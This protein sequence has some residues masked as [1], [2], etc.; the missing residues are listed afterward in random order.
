MYFQT[1]L[2]LCV[3][4]LTL[5]YRITAVRVIGRSVTIP[6]RHNANLFCQLTDTQETLTRI[7]WQKRTREKPENS[8]FFAITPDGEIEHI[9]GL[10]DRAEFIGNIQELIGSIGLK[11]VSL[12]D[13]GV[14]TCIFNIFPSGPFETEI[15]LT[16]LVP[17]VV[18][19]DPAIIPVAGDGNV[20]LASCTAAKGRPAAEVSWHLGTLADFLKVNTNQS[21]HPDGTYT[22]TSHLIGVA[23]KELNQVKIQCLVNHTALKTTLVEDYTIVIHYPPQVAYIS[24]VGNAT[25]AQEFLCEADGNPKPSSFTWRRVN[26][27]LPIPADN[28]RLLIPLTSDHNGLYLCEA[29]NQYG[30]VTGSIYVHVSTESSTQTPV[31]ILLIIAVL[32]CFVLVI[33]FR[34][35]LV[36]CLSQLWQR[37]SNYIQ[38]HLIRQHAQDPVPTQSPSQNTLSGRREEQELS[39]SPEQD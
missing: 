3:I 12:L 16:V 1:Y 26:K 28:D 30:S 34:K 32:I 4:V 29:S 21:L 31:I 39:L 17:P 25:K 33:W 9:N 18:S 14:Y 2:Q 11:N 35:T 7:T 20:T 6:A 5:L 36:A 10:K 8:I 15:T 22:V 23:S 24:S 19:V 13:E 27:T 37:I 38:S